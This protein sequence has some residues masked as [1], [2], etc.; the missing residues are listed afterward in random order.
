MLGT[1]DYKIIIYVKRPVLKVQKLA[2]LQIES[3][4]YRRL[5]SKIE[6]NRPR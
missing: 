6:R 3:I 4:R 5:E 1:F 2:A